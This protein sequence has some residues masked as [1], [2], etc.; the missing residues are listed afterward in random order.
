MAAVTGTTNTTTTTTVATPAG[1]TSVLA[2]TPSTARELLRNEVIIGTGVTL[3]GGVIGLA[4]GI[5]NNNKSKKSGFALVQSDLKAALEGAILGVIIAL[6]S[7]LLYRAFFHG[8]AL[9][10]QARIQQEQAL[11]RA[12]EARLQ[13]YATVS[14]VAP[15]VNEAGLQ[16]ATRLGIVQPSVVA[17]AAKAPAVVPITAAT[18]AAAP[19]IA[20]A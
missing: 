16:A 10:Q 12:Q 1:A 17:V 13:H 7:I 2:V 11:A 3:L 20:A 14:T 5:W 9:Y 6:A 18:A 15:T 8:Q 4:Y 19:V